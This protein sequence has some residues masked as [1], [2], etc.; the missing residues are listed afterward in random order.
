MFSLSDYSFILPP[1][2]IADSA[3]TPQHNARLITIAKEWGEILSED[4]FW[5]LDAYIPPE[6]VLFF[7]NSKVLRARVPLREKEIQKEDGAMSLLKEWEIFF[8]KKIDEER[9]EAMV[10]PGKKLRKWTQFQIGKYTLKI[11]EN[12][13]YG[14]ILRISG[15]E[16]F[17]FLEEHGELPLPPYI[18]YSKEKE[19]WY[20]TVFG[21]KHG[22][23]AA[24]TASLHFTEELLKKIENPK[25]YVTLHVW[26]GTFK[27]IDTSDIREYKIHEESV[28]IDILLFE[29]IMKYKKGG[30]KVIAVWT[31]V[32]RTLES[33]P[34]VWKELTE[35]ERAYTSHEVQ[36]YW[37]EIIEWEEMQNWT[38]Q[39][40]I[41]TSSKTLTFSTSIYITPWY[42]YKIVDELITNFHLPESSLLVLVASIIGQKR[43]L[44]IYRYAIE[45]AY[46]FYSFWDGMY[47]RSK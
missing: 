5:N 45:K 11:E 4:I 31:T 34:Y 29:K 32:C 35:Q 2:R 3:I 14:R 16:I 18:E 15:G 42:T 38:H 28:E 13:Q 17:S 43:L 22:S 10:R 21:E 37:D 40:H 6:R 41:N 23:V 12:T 26:L 33:L 1:E 47:I 24:P 9:F 39:V 36:N 20:E 44:E 7:N 8:I 46:R 25:E 30:K 19:K 27:W